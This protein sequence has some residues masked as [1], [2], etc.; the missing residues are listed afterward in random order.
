MIWLTTDTACVG[1]LGLALAFGLPLGFPL[2][3]LAVVGLAVVALAFALFD[4]PPWV[5]QPPPPLPWFC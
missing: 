3:A 4:Q 1:I 2:V 5:L